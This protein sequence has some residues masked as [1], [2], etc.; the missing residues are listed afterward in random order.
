MRQ[1]L[2]QEHAV[3]E[4]RWPRV[5]PVRASERIE[6]VDILRGFAVFGILVAN[7]A[8]FSGQSRD[9]QAWP[10]TI[11][12]VV[13]VLIRLL[14]EAKFYSLFSFLF[15][16]GMA[17][18]MV[19]V[20]AQGGRFVGLYLRRLVVL[21]AMGLLHG[22]LIWH[23]DI[24]TTYALYGFYCCSSANAPAEGYWQRPDSCYFSQSWSTC[25]GK[26]WM[27]FESGTP[28]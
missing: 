27:P 18:Q 24:L 16:W 9:L 14:V 6:F 12:R 2:A 20:E 10:G 4:K 11:D 8:G 3:F 25:L 17:V 5:V 22:I 13:L 15:G 26:G 1:A 28:T 21:L 23:G 7:M 19:R